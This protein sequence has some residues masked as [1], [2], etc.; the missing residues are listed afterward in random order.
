MKI[1]KAFLTKRTVFLLIVKS[2]RFSNKIA[3]MFD[4]IAMRSLLSH[5]VRKPVLPYPNN[6]GADQPAHS[7]SLISAFVVHCLDSIIPL[8]SI[9]EISSLY[10]A[11]VAFQIGLKLPWS[12]TPKTG[13]LVTR[14]N[15]VFNR[16]MFN[17]SR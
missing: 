13:F 8:V 15:Y 6:K 4:Y 11:S 12:Q 17:V 16:F 9:S 5:V 7:R 2:I 10:L 3:E 1:Y 14:F